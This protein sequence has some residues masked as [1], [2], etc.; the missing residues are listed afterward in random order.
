M[1]N[2]TL[3]FTVRHLEKGSFTW[4][5]LSGESLGAAFE[6]A[7]DIYLSVWHKAPDQIIMSCKEIH[8]N[9]R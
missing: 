9:R 5:E 3:Y 1:A 8:T 2:T 7:L 6:K 4:R